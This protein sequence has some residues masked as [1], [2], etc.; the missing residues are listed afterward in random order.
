MESSDSA[1]NELEPIMYRQEIENYFSVSPQGNI[2][3]PGKFE[4]EQLYAVHFWDLVLEGSGSLYDD[5]DQDVY[6]FDVEEED[7]AE[8]PELNDVKRVAVWEDTQGFVWCKT[9]PKG[10]DIDL[11]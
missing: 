7:R 11:D 4:S 1:A 2:A 6:L 8:F 10:L 3:S 9:D 5:N